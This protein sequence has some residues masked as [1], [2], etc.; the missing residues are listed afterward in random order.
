VEIKSQSRIAID[1]AVPIAIAQGLVAQ[2]HSSLYVA[3][4]S[5]SATLELPLKFNDCSLCWR[6]AGCSWTRYKFCSVQAMMLRLHSL[7][8][9]IGFLAMILLVSRTVMSL[10]MQ[11][12]TV[13]ADYRMLKVRKKRGGGG[14][15]LL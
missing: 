7:E 11:L 12:M 1:G 8:S 13:K 9:L 15:R 6:A 5:R 10:I 4:I 14:G 3:L 2:L